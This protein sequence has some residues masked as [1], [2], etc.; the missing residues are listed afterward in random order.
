MPTGRSWSNFAQ[1]TSDSGMQAT[2]LGT[3]VGSETLSSIVL[4]A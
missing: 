2:W 3:Y 1:R 4:L